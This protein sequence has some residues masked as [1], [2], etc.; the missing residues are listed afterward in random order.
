MIRSLPLL[1]CACGLPRVAEDP[2]V[3]GSALAGMLVVDGDE[4]ATAVVLLSAEDNPQPPL[5]TGSPVSFTTLAAASFGPVGAA[6]LTAPFALTDVPP[7]GWYLFGL[8]DVNADFH[9]GVDALASPT[10]GDYGGWHQDRVGGVPSPVQLGEAELLEGLLVGPLRRIEEPRPVFTAEE[11]QRAVFDG[12]IVRLDAVDVAA[13][14]AG[15]PL[16]VPAP[17]AEPCAAGFRFV[18]TDADGNG[19]ADSSPLLPL[20]EDRY[21]RVVFRWL[22][23]PYEADGVP[24]FDRGGIGDDVTIAAIGDPSPTGQ[25]LPAP[26]VFVDVTSLD[27]AWTG[28]GQ[29]IEPDG[30]SAV[31]AGADLPAGAWSATVI[32]AV[33]QL[34]TLPN[35]VGPGFD[36]ALPQPGRLSAADARQG[37]VFVR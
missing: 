27:V 4:A 29:R 12:A 28:F 11:D 1:L 7:G 3:P 32:T 35:E 31:L 23:V 34:W 20:F 18:R 5:G 24:A 2:D 33:G 6:T 16:D 30:S 19:S 9:P 14:F 10:C 15:I 36:A 21:P 22:G 37:V 26:G 25:A 13:D 8:V 17:G